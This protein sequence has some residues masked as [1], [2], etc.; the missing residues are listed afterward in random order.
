MPVYNVE[1]YLSASV[2]SILKQTFTDFDFLIIND[3]STDNTMAIA[4]HYAALDSRIKIID[5]PHN[6]GLCSA[7]NIGL[8]HIQSKYIS[9]TDGDDISELNRLK[10]QFDFLESYPDYAFCGTW[11]N[12]FKKNIQEGIISD[13]CPTEDEDIRLSL[14]FCKSWG[15]HP[16]LRN[17][18][19][20]NHNLSYNIMYS[21]SEDYELYYQIS[22]VAKVANLPQVLYHYRG[23]EHSITGAQR[24]QQIAQNKEIVKKQLKELFQEIK[25]VDL[26]LYVKFLFS[27]INFNLKQLP[28]LSIFL[29]NIIKKNELNKIYFCD[30]FRYYLESH[31][32]YFLNRYTQRGLSIWYLYQFGSINKN[33]KIGFKNNIIFFLDCLL[34]RK[35]SYYADKQSTGYSSFADI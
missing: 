30:K 14:F 9:R 23:N 22:K 24:P 4:E 29:L 31:W 13:F 5:L 16:L 3:G 34:K 32:F 21:P 35:S 2:E 10:A 28:I 18:T 19:L 33:F 8:A 25:E 26:E 20:Q 11:V 15:G 6:I 7:A 27:D 12:Y 1:K 17:E